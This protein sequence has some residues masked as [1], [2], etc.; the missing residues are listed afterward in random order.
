MR[1]YAFLQHKIDIF[2]DSIPGHSKN[3]RCL[4]SASI[5]QIGVK[6]NRDI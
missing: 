6:F 4:V 1:E 5:G 2:I 3:A